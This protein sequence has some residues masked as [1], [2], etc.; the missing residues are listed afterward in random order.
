[1]IFQNSAAQNQF[2]IMRYLASYPVGHP[3]R[4][5][6]GHHIGCHLARCFVGY[7]VGLGNDRLTAIAAN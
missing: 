7:L 3:A 6:A 4:H 5:P 1:V 2:E